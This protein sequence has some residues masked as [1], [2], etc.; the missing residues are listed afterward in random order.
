MNIA[1]SQNVLDDIG[2]VMYQGDRIGIIGPNGTEKTTFFLTIAGI[3]NP[4]AG[5]IKLFG[6]AVVHGQFRPKLGMVLQNQDDQLFCPTVWDDIAFGP[7]NMGL[8][9][10]EVIIRVEYAVDLL[11]ISQLVDRAPHQLSGGEKRLVAIAG[12][13]AMDSRFVIYD[14][15]TS[16]LD[17]RYR[18]KLINPLQNK[19]TH[20]GML[21]ASR[22]LELVLE[23]CNRV[24]LIDEGKII[25]DG[26]PIE[27]L[28]NEK[29][30][31]NHGLET[32]YSLLFGKVTYSN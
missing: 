28:S 32:P 10:D 16:N 26:K 11:D 17:M 30:L 19:Q 20:E 15:P 8:S 29:L 21:I 13:I 5:N 7:S 2:L 18:R 14:E 9:K 4:S 24:I 3:N 31:Q 23:V 1:E 12:I 27:I 25:T 6:E 22:D